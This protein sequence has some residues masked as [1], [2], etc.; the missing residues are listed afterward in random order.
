[1]TRD[2]WLLPEGVEEI[3]PPAARHA[4]Q[5]RRDLLDLLERWGYELIMPP[6]IEYLESLLTGVG[7]EL[8]LR[9]FKL[10]DQLTGRLMGIRADMTPQAARV[11]AHYLR[12][13]GPVRLCYLGP[14]LRTRPDEF[15][16]AR[17]P[18]QIG[19]ELFG[20]AGAR[21]DR[22]VLRLMLA[23]LAAAGFGDLHVD[24]GHVGIYRALVQE[25]GITGAAEDTLLAALRRR[26]RPEIRALLA[27]LSLSNTQ[28]EYFEVL[29]DLHGPLDDLAAAVDRLSGAGEGVCTALAR[30]QTIASSVQQTEPGIRWHFD[31][32]ELNGYGYYTGVVFA[33]FTPGYGQAVAQGGRYDEIGRAFGRSRPAVGF[34]ADLRLLLKLQDRETPPPR[35]IFAPADDDPELRAMIGA[36]RGQGQRV[37]EALQDEVTEAE[38]L[39]CDRILIHRKGRWTVED[40]H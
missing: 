32:A 25:A 3:L 13:E 6:L 27:A 11:D 15:G 2:R 39:G 30:L 22:E 20:H 26:S 24:I 34:G 7:E 40:R 17:E 5:L 12:R 18:W 36:L 19:A 28:R 1:M 8:D 29:T 21:A 35:V 10:T 16:A 14:V 38:A 23:L 37:I 33:A 31:L 4:E 9:T